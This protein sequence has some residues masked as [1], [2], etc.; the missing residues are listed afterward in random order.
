MITITGTETNTLLTEME[1]T[2]AVFEKYLA[3]GQGNTREHGAAMRASLDLS[4]A[5]V[6]WRKALVPIE[7]V[8]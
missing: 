4:A 7:G 3:R 2:V 1:R 5:L 8:K 6:R